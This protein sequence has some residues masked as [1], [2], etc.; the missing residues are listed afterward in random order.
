M[1]K[2]G[3]LLLAAMMV[4]GWCTACADWGRLADREAVPGTNP[5]TQPDAESVV[6]P[7]QEAAMDDQPEGDPEADLPSN[8]SLT[9]YDTDTEESRTV[10]APE[11]Q[12]VKLAYMEEQDSHAVAL[13]ADGAIHLYFPEEDQWVVN[14]LQIADPDDGQYNS[15]CFHTMVLVK[16]DKS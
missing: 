14:P 3:M 16:L 4:F 15:N 10:Q 8:A 1:R 5:E 6:V 7:N 12:V 9:F 13:F 2:W 11:A